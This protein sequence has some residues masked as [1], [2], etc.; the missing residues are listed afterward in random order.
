MRQG[1]IK[2]NVIE[3]RRWGWVGSEGIVRKEC[4]SKVRE[5]RRLEMA[6]VKTRAEIERKASR[7]TKKHTEKKEIVKWF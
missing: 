6:R 2:I 5:E 4:E 3:A 7:G 1:K